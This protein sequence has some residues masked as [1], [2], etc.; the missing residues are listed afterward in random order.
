MKLG[1]VAARLE[2]EAQ[3]ATDSTTAH[4]LTLPTLLFLMFDV[5]FI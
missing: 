5:N 2:A 3:A 4:V 1:L